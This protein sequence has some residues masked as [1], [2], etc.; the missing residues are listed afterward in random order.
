MAYADSLELKQQIQSMTAV[1][2]PEKVAKLLISVQK[3]LEER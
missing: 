2:L 1:G 3:A